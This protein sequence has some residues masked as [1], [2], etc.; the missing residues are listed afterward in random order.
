VFPDFLQSL[1][2]ELQSINILA[3]EVG[4]I[5]TITKHGNTDIETPNILVE[6]TPQISL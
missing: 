5:R 3:Q 2:I 1:F 6:L 4:M